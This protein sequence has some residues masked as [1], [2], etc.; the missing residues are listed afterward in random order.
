M[1][2]CRIK[3]LKLVASEDKEILNADDADQ[4]EYTLESTEKRELLNRTLED[5]NI[6]PLK[7]YSVPHHSRHLHG[8]RKLQQARKVFNKI[9]DQLKSRLADALVVTEDVNYDENGKCEL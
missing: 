3:Y 6:S 8:K 1:P 9:E 4:V 7:L 5:M 2:S